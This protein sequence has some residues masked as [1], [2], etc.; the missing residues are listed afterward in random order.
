MNSATL[1]RIAE[2]REGHTAADVAALLAADYSTA[3]N[4]LV[5]HLSGFLTGTS[6]FGPFLLYRAGTLPAELE[7]FRLALSQLDYILTQLRG[8]VENG[9]TVGGFVQTTD[10]T[11]GAQTRQL[12][13]TLVAGSLLTAG[14]AT[15]FLALGGGYRYERATAEEIAA[16]W[17]NQDVEDELAALRFDVATAY[18]AAVEAIDS[19]ER[20]RS[21]LA[22]NFAAALGAP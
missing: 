7:P 5:D 22:A 10:P 19:G 4:I 1:A 16:A 6:L 21:T 20:N 15:G 14:E 11:I 17:A 8:R 18:N 3:E 2:L 13:D 12:L 9:A